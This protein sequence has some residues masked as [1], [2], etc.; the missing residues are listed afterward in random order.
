ML[1]WLVENDCKQK[2]GHFPSFS[3]GFR[4]ILLLS[5]VE[6]PRYSENDTADSLDNTCIKI[7]ALLS[8]AELASQAL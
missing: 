4:K 8:P 7:N 2:S 5:D 1:K 6:L 3:C